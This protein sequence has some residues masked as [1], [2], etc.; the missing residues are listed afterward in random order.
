MD[1]YLND[2]LNILI[3]NDLPDDVLEACMAYAAQLRQ[4]GLPVIFDRDHLAYLLGIK[5]TRLTYCVASQDSHYTSFEIPKK[6]GG[7]RVIDA[8]S[9]E[10]KAI[11]RWILDQILVR[12]HTSQHAYG[13]IRGRSIVDNARCHM[14]KQCVV[15]IDIQDFFQSIGIDSVFRIFYYYG[16]SREVS[17]YLARI[18]TYRGHLPQGSPAS[19][20]LANIAF[21]KA[22]KRLSM[23]SSTYNASYSRYAD[24]ITFSGSGNLDNIL[25]PA[26]QI[27]NDEGFSHNPSKTRIARNHQRQEVTGLIVNNDTVHVRKS[28]KRKFFQE[29]YYCKKYGVS[30]HMEHLNQNKLFYKEHLYGKAYFISMVEPATGKRALEALDSID[31]DY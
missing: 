30:N 6:S 8:P 1:R 24:D 19:P 11:Q 12:M 26:I 14:G 22:D 9:A 21:L 10:L 20:Y 4:N 31:W 3:V 15:G 5:S 17:Y 18:C 2:L 25:E 13:F 7:Q 28:F 27:L 16:Y 23:L 29:I